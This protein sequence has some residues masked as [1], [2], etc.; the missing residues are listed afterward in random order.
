VNDSSTLPEQLHRLNEEAEGEEALRAILAR[1]EIFAGKVNEG[2]HQADFQTRRELIRVLVK[3]IEI[4]E[5]QIRVVFR[6]S[7]LSPA[8]PFEGASLIGNIGGGVYIREHFKGGE[9]PI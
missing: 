8:P 9:P 7:P 4:D 2:L 1:L 5:Q 3:R 6:I